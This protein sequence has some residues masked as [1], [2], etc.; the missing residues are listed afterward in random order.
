MSKFTKSI[1]RKFEFE[2]D[3]VEVTLE[4]MKRKDAMKLMPFVGEPDEDGTVKMTFSNQMEMLDMTGDLLPKYVKR[5]SGLVDADGADVSVDTMCDEAYFLDLIG[6]IVQELME[7]SFMTKAERKKSNASQEKD[8][9]EQDT[10][11]SS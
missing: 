5:I 4:R 1:I 8:S 11:E 7:S 9:Q 6:K 10:Q 2:D 3:L